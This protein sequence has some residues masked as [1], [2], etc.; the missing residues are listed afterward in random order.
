MHCVVVFI[1][2]VSFPEFALSCVL[3]DQLDSNEYLTIDSASLLHCPGSADDEPCCRGVE[4]HVCLAAGILTPSVQPC[5][6]THQH[7]SSSC[8]AAAAA[9][10]VVLRLS[11]L[12]K[13]LSLTR[14]HS[15]PAATCCAG[16]SHLFDCFSFIHLFNSID[17]HT[18]INFIKE[19]NFY[20]QL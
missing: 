6:S 7:P 17:N 13:Q 20:H 3:I 12:L 5:L 11:S 9:E 18:I 16:E 15:Q 4:A 14:F 8:S 19:I 2:D 1:K 10:N